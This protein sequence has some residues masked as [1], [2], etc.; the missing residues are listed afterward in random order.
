MP[1]RSGTA[2]PSGSSD[3]RSSLADRCLRVARSRPIPRRA[4]PRRRRTRS[5]SSR[6]RRSSTGRSRRASSSASAGISRMSR[7]RRSSRPRISPAPTSISRRSSDSRRTPSRSTSTASGASRS[8]TCSRSSSSR[9]SGSATR[10][11]SD[12]IIV[13]DTVYH[14]GAT[15]NTTAG[16][17]YYGLTYRY[18][19]WRRERWE[20]GAGLGIDVMN[21]SAGFGVKATVQGAR[22]QRADEREHR[23]P[24]PDA[25]H[26]RRLGDDPAPLPAR[27]LPD[28][29]HR[30]RR[31]LRRRGPRPADRGRVVS[32]S[33][34]TDSGSAGTMWASTSRRRSRMART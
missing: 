15:I 10:T 24:R 25:R 1:S 13:N 6:C 31:E 5:A 20:L 19:I 34:T 4:K 33:T 17:E 32:A 26:L 12:S 21:L 27:H 23:R 29:L 8:D 7:R 18:Y 14:A 9:S 30:E 22:R 28:A 16:L 11:I 2:L 3:R